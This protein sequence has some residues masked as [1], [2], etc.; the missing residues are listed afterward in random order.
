[1]TL[2][3]QAHDVIGDPETY[4]RRL[5]I[6]LDTHGISHARLARQMEVCPTQ[7]SRWMAERVRPSMESMLRMDEALD[8]LLY[9]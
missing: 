7:L 9:S 4:M 6:T 2:R 5:R 1:M 3:E 8:A